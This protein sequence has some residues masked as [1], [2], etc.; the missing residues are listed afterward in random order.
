MTK[1][2]GDPVE[3]ANARVKRKRTLG[4]K[5]IS[6][7]ALGSGARGRGQHVLLCYAFGIICTT[8]LIVRSV[9]ISQA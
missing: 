3:G 9:A 6:T 7:L 8:F 5:R 1:R 2:Q 4:V